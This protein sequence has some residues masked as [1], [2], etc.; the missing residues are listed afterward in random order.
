MS[1]TR[2]TSQR[3][4]TR[5][6]TSSTDT[7][8]VASD[9]EESTA[10]PVESTQ[11]AWMPD[12]HVSRCYSCSTPFTL[13]RRRHHCRICGMVFCSKCSKWS[14]ETAKGKVRCCKNCASEQGNHVDEKGAGVKV[15]KK[16]E[17]KEKKEKKGRRENSQLNR[18]NEHGV[19]KNVADSQ[20][21][22]ERSSGAVFRKNSSMGSIDSSVFADEVRLR[23]AQKAKSIDNS[24]ANTTLFASRHRG[25]R[26]S[27]RRRTRR[28]SPGPSSS[29]WT[30]PT[31]NLSSRV[32]EGLQPRE[33]IRRRRESGG[34][35]HPCVPIG[36]QFLPPSLP[37][38]RTCS[39]LARRSSPLVLWS[40]PLEFRQES[41]PSSLTSRRRTTSRFYPR[42]LGV[43]IGIRSPS[44]T[45]PAPSGGGQA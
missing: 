21:G 34:L 3:N 4:L 7:T 2:P 39:R 6:E 37:C 36:G 22:R 35:R 17:K 44:R 41:S 9:G 31:G 43:R 13:T 25:T 27:T 28:S 45:S 42:I 30:V 10:P 23:F 16:K 1:L 40:P 15:V 24:T 20:R 8:T 38:A 29:A 19:M 14:V 18:G 11:V 26:P 32:T 33:T 12:S 5:E